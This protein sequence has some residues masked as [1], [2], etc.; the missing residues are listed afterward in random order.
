MK[1]VCNI[2]SYVHEGEKKPDIC[3]VCEAPAEKFSQVEE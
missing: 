2:C 1:W 3:P